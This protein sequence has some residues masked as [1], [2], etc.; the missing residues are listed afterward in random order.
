MRILKSKFRFWNF[1]QI[2]IN[3]SFIFIV[4]RIKAKYKYDIYNN[5]LLNEYDKEEN[6][7]VTVLL[8]LPVSK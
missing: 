3:Y 1:L 4:I 7:A 2:I 5:D 8:L 6:V